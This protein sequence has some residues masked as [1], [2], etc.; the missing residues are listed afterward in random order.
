MRNTTCLYMPSVVSGARNSLISIISVVI[1][2]ESFYVY[3]FTESVKVN[4][5]KKYTNSVKEEKDCNKGR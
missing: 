2:W 5:R 4:K 3:I 1:Y